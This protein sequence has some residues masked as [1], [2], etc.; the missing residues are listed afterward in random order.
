MARTLPAVGR[1]R[2]A[3]VPT[4][5]AGEV[6]LA[7]V[8]GATLA[9]AWSD[10]TP[11]GDPFDTVGTAPTGIAALQVSGNNLYSNKPSLRYKPPVMAPPPQ[12]A[13]P[14]APPVQLLIS[15]LNVH[16]AVEP[17]GV[18]RHGVMKTPV[19]SWNAGW[20]MGG[21]V[22]GAPGDAVIEG[23]AGFPGQPMIFGRLST[24]HKGDKIIIVL[25]DGSRHLFLVASMA[26]LPIGRA[27]AGMGEPYG[28]PRLTLI[29]CTGSFDDQKYS[30]S[31]R[32]VVEATYAGT[33]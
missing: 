12:P 10:A 5:L 6:A 33:I 8:L 25:H 29:T 32:L 23:H 1:L 13:I 27:P 21:P 19:N 18:D 31:Q 7:A 14:T 30:Y 28:P 4:T 22:P 2:L 16:R 20:Y 11:N 9:F 3:H 17:V 24:L 26:T 15:K